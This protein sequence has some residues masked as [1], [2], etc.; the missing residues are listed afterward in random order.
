[1][2]NVSSLFMKGAMWMLITRISIKSLGLVSSIILARLLLP[3]DFGLVAIAMSFYAFILIFG[4]VGFNAALIQKE[5]AKSSDF[6]T[7]WTIG[8]VFGVVAAIIFAFAA[9]YIANYF[10]DPRLI[11][12]VY[13]IA[14]MFI[15]NGFVNVGVIN[16]QKQLDF[17]QEFKYQLMPKLISFFMTMFLA[18]SL[19]SYWALVYGMLFHQLLITVTSY[20][21]S[22][23]RP[24]LGFKGFASLFNFSKWVVINQLLFYLNSRSVGMIVGKMIS[25][26]ATGIYG[27]SGEL[28]MLPVTEVVAPINKAAFPA[29][30]KLQNDR[31]KLIEL[32]LQT[33]SLIA[34][35]SVPAALG[36]NAIAEV[37]VPVV[38]GGKWLEAIP[39]IELISIGGFFVAISSNNGFVFTAIGKPYIS[40]C[41]SLIRVTTLLFFVWWF[42]Q[43][44]GM[45]GAAIGMLIAAVMGLVVSYCFLYWQLKVNLFNL[46]KCFR[47]PLISGICMYILLSYIKALY[48]DVSII[49]LILML[50]S[51]I[52]SY[53]LVL[54]VLWFLEGKPSG[55]ESDVINKMKKQLT[56]KYG[57]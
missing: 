12:I 13:Y 43:D 1:M 30:A 23:F 48:L 46:I 54:L 14:L 5:N 45:V 20:L 33:I 8:V 31:P 22:D 56:A 37:M 32:Y 18:F 9:P 44:Y 38:L 15:F 2:S 36:L 11:E 16:F 40:T 47:R 55:L 26:K 39:V 57:S 53:V 19:R 52:V 25:A 21:M 50:V 35:V 49:L 41:N 29:Y 3:T 24:K 42:I 34:L 17:K 7:I 51:G 28:S 6:D 27:L 10:N 4:S